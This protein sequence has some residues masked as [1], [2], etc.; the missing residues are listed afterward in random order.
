MAI[1]FV[2]RRSYCKIRNNGFSSGNVC[3]S[4]S[5]FGFFPRYYS[6]NNDILNNG[7]FTNSTILVENGF[8]VQELPV[9]VR[10][11]KDIIEVEKPP[12]ECEQSS[13]DSHDY[14]LIKAEFQQCMHL[15]DIFTLLSKC[16]KIT[17]NIALGAMERI[18]DLEKEPLSTP[19]VP[20]STIHVNLAKGAI[21]DKLL[22]VVM[23]TEDTQTILNILHSN[24]SFM[25]PYKPRFSDELLLRVID[26]Q[27]SVEQLCEFILFLM[28][29]NMDSK[30]SDT[31]DKLWVGFVDREHEI[32]GI[33]IALI[34][35]ILPG[36]KASKKTI[37]TLMEQKLADLWHSIKV[38]GMQEILNTFLQEK[39]LSLQSFAVVGQWFYFNLH[40][41]DEDVM[42]DII[43]KFTRLNYTDDVIE[44]AIEKYMK[45]KG[46]KID[47]QILIVGILNHCMRFQIHNP[48]ILEECSKYFI[49]NGRSV[50]ISFL[51]SF[52]Y[53]FGYLNYNPKNHKQFWSLAED[54]INEKFEKMISDDICSAVLSHLYA[55]VYPMKVVR[56]LFSAEY[57][58]TVNNPETL[59]KL[60][61]IDTALA[62]ECEDYVGPF[63]PK[64]QWSKSIAQ[65]G[66]IRNI[67]E[68]IKGSLLKLASGDE[69][70]STAVLIPFLY[71][72]ET[73]LIDVMV[74]PVS[75]ETASFNWK[76]KSAKN[77]N[78]ALLI[79][80]PDHFC[81]HSKQLIGPQMMKKKHL[82]LLGMRVASAKY[83]VLSQFYI[84]RNKSALE[85]YL[86]ECILNAEDS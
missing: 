56:R 2:L 24:S 9:V 66:R 47:S 69:K 53:P 49:I 33:N 52:I 6:D 65:D 36:F 26:N 83:S 5:N 80:L 41:L 39:Y 44:K 46:T 3:T 14:H 37:L 84:S 68:K 16:T 54:I 38:S 72:D 10:K 31:M 50:P 62:L 57:L 18:Y 40:A 64:D 17:P 82:K 20:A 22:K 59:R 11:M 13:Q 70:V 8:N 63:M 48:N 32:N 43:S 45:L 4:F 75:L 29:N 81:A 28:E 60:H 73:Y 25:E 74:H 34:F 19:Y 55:G 42:L 51:K 21:L 77:E 27:L 85:N 12:T 61:L 58:V 1:P 67:L 35:K 15:R 76:L 30:Y 78:T 71:S 7:E 23:K 86:K 79:H